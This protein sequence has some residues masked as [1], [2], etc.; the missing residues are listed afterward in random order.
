MWFPGD[1]DSG[2]IVVSAAARNPAWYRNIA[3]HR[4]VLRPLAVLA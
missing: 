1:D 3:A 4:V 2:L